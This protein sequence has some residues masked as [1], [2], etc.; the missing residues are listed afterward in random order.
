[1]KNDESAKVTVKTSLKRTIKRIW[2]VFCLAIATLFAFAFLT[3]MLT[4]SNYFSSAKAEPFRRY[5]RQI[6]FEFVSWTVDALFNKSLWGAAGFQKFLVEETATTFVRGYFEQVARVQNLDYQLTL[7]YADPAVKNPEQKSE[8]LRAELTEARQ[9]MTDMAPLAESIL[10]QQLSVILAE[11]KLTFL[12]QPLPPVAFKASELPLNLVISPRDRIE[13]YVALSLLP[14]MSADEKEQLEAQIQTEMGYSALVTPIGGIGTYPTMVM[15]TSNFVWITEVISH[16]WTHNYLTL[17]P[18]GIRYDQS[19]ELRVIN[20][21]TANLVG[22]ELGVLLLKRFYPDLAP[23]EAPNQSQP[24]TTPTEAVVEQPVFNFNA[25]MRETR[26]MVDDMLLEGKIDEAEAYMAMR[27][28]FFWENGYLIRKLN[29][30]YFAFHGAYNDVPGGGAAGEDPV[31]PAV[32]RLR[33]QSESLAAFMVKI[34][35]VTS[36]QQLL[37]LLNE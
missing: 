21:T 8:Q 13:Q 34:S 12:G 25:E 29:Q 31:G 19:P 17:R 37:D 35:G 18:L 1:M 16:E 7:I 22:K 20:E 24:A 3:L 4:Y 10:Q 6:E 9:L 28:Q 36:F 32:T 27:R 26:V 11:Q 30:A 2:R 33:A 15:Q 23:V 14:G 5:T